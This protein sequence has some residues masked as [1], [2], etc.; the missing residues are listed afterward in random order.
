[1]QLKKHAISCNKYLE[2]VDWVKSI[3]HTFSS[4]GNLT[5]MLHVVTGAGIVGVHFPGCAETFDTGVQGQQESPRRTRIQGQETQDSHQKVHRFKQGDILAIPAGAVHWCYNDGNED[6]VAT[7][8]NDLNN[9]SNQLDKQS[10]LFFLAGGLSSQ[11]I[12]GQQGQRGQ[13]RQ[14]GQQGRQGFQGGSL[15]FQN[16]FAGFD[17]ELLAESFNSDPQIIR[18]MQES[19]ER[20]LIVK[21]QQPMQFVTPEEEQQ[22]W[23]PRQRQSP[24]Q[25]G[26]QGGGAS[27]GLEEKICSSKILYNLDT[28]READIFSRQAG[29]LNMVNEHKLPILSYLDLSAEKGHLQQNALLSPHWSINS[30]TIIYVLRGDAQVQVVSNNGEAV[31]DEQVNRGDFFVVPQF[32]AST[33]RAGQNGFEWVAFKTNKSPMKSPVAGYTSVIRACPL[34]VLTNAYQISPSQ[35][36]NLKTNR[37]TESILLSPQWTGQQRS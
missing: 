35:A 20:G 23:Q 24:R 29:K 34:E 37:E 22:Q 33:A 26:Q 8:I 2:Y 7:A 12:Q 25:R 28:Q 17:T 31:L 13:Q 1:M 10:R 21:V 18:A 19:G 15:N 9:P 4:Q 5:N 6:V 27:N 32:F 30:H 14:Q 11:H 3:K 16:I 36:Q